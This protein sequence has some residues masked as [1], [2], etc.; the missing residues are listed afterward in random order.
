[1]TK[2][3]EYQLQPDCDKV[4]RT[5]YPLSFITDFPMNYLLPK[6]LKEV[7]LQI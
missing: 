5:F 6:Q 2:V 4:L 1:M 3:S 7:E